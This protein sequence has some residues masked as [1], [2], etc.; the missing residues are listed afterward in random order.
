MASTGTKAG[1]S[2]NG[3][4]ATP[5]AKAKQAGESMTGVAGRAKGPL[6]AAGLTAAAVAGG[7]VLGRAGGGNRAGLL[8]RRRK[9]LGLRIGPKTGLERTAE[10]LEKLAD[11]IGS[12]AGKASATTDDVRKIREE[13]E[14]A[15]RQSPVEVLLDGLTHRRGAHKRET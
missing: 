6:A 12:A 1:D 9:V 14:Q 11:S 5:A 10:V 15:N 13:L 8:P 2:P 7:Y 4:I 3:F